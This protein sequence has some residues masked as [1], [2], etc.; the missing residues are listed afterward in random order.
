MK[1]HF[2]FIGLIFSFLC[3]GCQRNSTFKES[4]TFKG[5]VYTGHKDQAGNIIA[6]TP[7]GNAKVVCTNTA[8]ETKTIQDGSYVLNVNAVRWFKGSDSETYVITALSQDGFNEKTSVSG[9]PGDTVT[10][11]SFVLYHHTED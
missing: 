4:I 7:L 11:K 1:Q 9:K 6:D 2:Y 10:V 5:F 3:L 8:E